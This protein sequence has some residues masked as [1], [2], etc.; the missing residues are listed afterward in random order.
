MH[1]ID[2]PEEVVKITHDVLISTG[3]ENTEVVGL[4]GTDSVDREGLLHVLEIDELGHLSIGVAGDVHQRA[5][6]IGHF[7]ETVDRHDREELSESP[8]IE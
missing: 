2:A 6:A 5:A 8:V 4:A 1:L 3:K 7:V